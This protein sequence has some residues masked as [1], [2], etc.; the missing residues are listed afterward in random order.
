MAL[1]FSLFPWVS[2]RLLGGGI[3]P[4]FS[5]IM[6]I[7]LSLSIVVNK[8]IS[9]SYILFLLPIFFIIFTSFSTELSNVLYLREL[10]G[11]AFMAMS[12]I[13]FQ[14]YIRLFGFPRKIILGSIY[15]SLFAGLMQVLID[16]KVIDFIVGARTTRERGVTGFATE[17]G[18]YGLHLTLLSSLL[19][20]S[21]KDEILKPLMLGLIG[22]VFS[23]SI[24][25]AYFYFTFVG[26]VLVLRSTIS[27]KVGIVF[28]VI[29]SMAYYFILADLRFGSIITLFL[30]D[31]F[32]GVL[33]DASASTRSSQSITP[34]IISYY[35]NF[36][37]AYDSLTSMK[38]LVFD[39]AV[40]YNLLA[41][42]DKIGSYF[43]RLVFHFGLFFLIPV[44]LGLFYLLMLVRL[45]K[46]I[47]ILFVVLA[48]FP[49]FSPG[50][51]VI[52][53]FFVCFIQTF[54]KSHS[55]SFT[56]ESK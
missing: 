23:S 32:E 35:N 28:L 40:I 39:N 19:L 55:T 34:F 18:F 24:V 51:P 15:L 48:T 38:S 45:R 52:M 4:F 56:K 22:V 37:P 3:Q 8:S 50:Y 44:F 49:A 21:I 9:R 2:F 12:F 20:F 30:N 43:G 26:S 6:F 54:S 29:G 33:T 47:A 1:V 27:L 25:G 7:A 41:E 46:L 16:E 31:G 13:F 42:D 53:Y 14:Q 10:A 17:P 11:Y 36:L 5:V